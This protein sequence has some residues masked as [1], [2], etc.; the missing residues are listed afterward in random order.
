V[1]PEITIRQASRSDAAAAAQ[2]T[3][4]TMGGLA[5]YLLGLGDRDCALAALGGLAARPRNRF[6][7]QLTDLALV[8]GDVT[9][10]LTSYPEEEMRR[11]DLG[12]GWQMM[13][14]CGV[15]DFPRFVRRSLTLAS[16][17]EAKAGEYFINSI[18][19]LPGF[20]RQGIATRLMTLAETKARQRGLDRCSLSVEVDNDAAC[21][22][23]ERL[24]Y[25]IVDTM[26]WPRL[27]RLIGHSGMHRMVKSLA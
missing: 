20:R 3:Y 11:L 8:A 1:D 2:L 25:R 13:Q 5:D 19:V 6:S 14:I 26:H 18:A 24:G 21:R 16:L 9:G 12:M 27:E 15:G 23:Y 7:Y 17:K 4:L 22:L 10:L